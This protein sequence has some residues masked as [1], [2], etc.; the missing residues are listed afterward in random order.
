MNIRE[1]K[2]WLEGFEEAIDKAPTEAQW[3]KLRTKL[4]SL[5]PESPTYVPSPYPVYP[6]YP[7]YP[8]SPSY[9][10][11]RFIITSGLSF[12]GRT[13]SGSNGDTYC[14]NVP[15]TYTSRGRLS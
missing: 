9:P 6:V 7:A 8:V 15:I 14:P 12:D 4:E 13:I 2:A 1:F 11:D 3:K 10:W 5:D